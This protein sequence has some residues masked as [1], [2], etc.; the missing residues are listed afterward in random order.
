MMKILNLKF[1]LI[2]LSFLFSVFACEDQIN[3]IADPTVGNPN[4]FFGSNFRDKFESLNNVIYTFEFD[5][6]TGG[7]YEFP[8]DSRIDF[9][10]YTLRTPGDTSPCTCSKV[11]AKVTFIRKQKDMVAAQIGT[12]AEND[13]ILVSGGMVDVR[14]YCENVELELIPGSKYSLRLSM[15]LKDF[16]E[17]Y[18]MFYGDEKDF[19]TVWVES[20]K[21]PSIQDNVIFSEWE[22]R[23]NSDV[24]GILCFPEKLRKVNCDYFVKMDPALMTKPCVKPIV[25]STGDTILFFTYSVFK[26]L[27]AVIA[28]CCNNGSIDEICFPLIPIGEDVVYIAIGKG[29]NDYYLGHVRK[30][31]EPNE[32]VRIQTS[33][34]SEAELKTFISTL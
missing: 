5:P 25:A 8:D 23:S 6:K 27:N 12:N 16:K 13:R 32:L 7:G 10:A 22:T 29:I 19:G 28:P 21:D 4:Q 1:N 11:I 9:N 30:N 24:T 3:F 34:V 15:E 20:D 33:K 17:E 31:I 18:E 2:A 14:I 26:N